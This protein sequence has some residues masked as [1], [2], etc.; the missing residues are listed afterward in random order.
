MPK[1]APA[2]DGWVLS[3]APAV[4]IG[5]SEGDRITGLRGAARLSDHR[6][7]LA[8][9]GTNELRY[10]DPAG[11][12]LSTAGGTGDGPGEFGSLTRIEVSRE[13]SVF[14]WD[15]RL[16]R[17]TVFDAGGTPVRSVTLRRAGEGMRATF[18][19]RFSDG[20]L[21]VT[22]RRVMSPSELT[23]GQR[24]EGTTAFLRYAPDGTPG[25]TIGR[26]PWRP[27]YI[28]IPA[29]GAF[30]VY[31]IPF[32]T[33]TLYKVHG[34]GLYTASAEAFEVRVFAPDGTLRRIVR[35]E[36]L[37]PLLSR[38]MVETFVQAVLQRIA[39]P[40]GRRLAGLAYEAMPYP[41]HVPALEGI[42]IG[43]DGSLWVKEFRLPGQSRETWSVFDAAG[44]LRR[45]VE[46]AESFLPTQAGEDWILGTWRNPDGPP[47]VRL[48]GVQRRGTRH[49]E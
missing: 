8:D 30:T 39:D 36:H 19:G 3:E 33:G 11:R 17:L 21:L 37:R 4:E 42:L 6:I 5:G 41:S 46:L 15:E 2:T 32:E 25:D 22:H 40:D 16:R 9:A 14:A 1:G 35:K 24:L 44:A 28:Q 34:D 38:S 13:D 27:S 48:Y 49:T 23:D 45:R 26:F 43:E 20:S 47:T 29:R 7:L 12:L 10:Y 18:A 31:S